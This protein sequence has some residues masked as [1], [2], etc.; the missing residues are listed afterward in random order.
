[1]SPGHDAAIVGEVPVDAVGTYRLRPPVKPLTLGELAA[2]DEA[3]VGEFGA[4]V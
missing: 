4:N 2:L 1:M 3:P